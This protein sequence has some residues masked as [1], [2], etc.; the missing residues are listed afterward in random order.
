MIA[1][2]IVGSVVFVYLIT[3]VIA[4]VAEGMDYVIY[5][6]MKRNDK[7]SPYV[8]NDEGLLELADKPLLAKL[9]MPGWNIVALKN[10]EKNYIKYLAKEDSEKSGYSNCFANEKVRKL[11]DEFYIAS[12]KEIIVKKANDNASGFYRKIPFFMES[13][14]KAIYQEAYLKAVSKRD[15]AKNIVKE[16]YK[17]LG[18]NSDLVPISDSDFEK[19]VND[20]A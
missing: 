17:D 20:A 12:R 7:N 9:L 13:F 8:R 10:A 4:V 3:Q 18:K 6:D 19:I 14:E 2:I 5:G 15:S 11:Y 1:L 16:R